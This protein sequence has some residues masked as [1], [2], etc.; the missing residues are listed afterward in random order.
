MNNHTVFDEAK[1]IWSGE[2]TS[3]LPNFDSKKSVGSAVI[4]VLERFPDNV[5][6][7]SSDFQAYFI[8]KLN[9]ALN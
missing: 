2:G 8:R 4:E 3:V 1:K 5:G 7:V 6:Q 9:S